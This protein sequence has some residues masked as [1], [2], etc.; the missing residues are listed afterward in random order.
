MVI[1]GGLA[2][3][4]DGFKDSAQDGLKHQVWDLGPEQPEA[5]GDLRVRG[6]EQA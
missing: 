3:G 1:F 6:Y 5:H 4:N 2:S